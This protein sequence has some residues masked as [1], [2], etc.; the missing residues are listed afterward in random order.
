[1]TTTQRV[2]TLYIHTNASPLPLP[3]TMRQLV[4][5]RQ[6]IARVVAEVRV[7][8]RNP[9]GRHELVH[10]AAHVRVKVAAHLQTSADDR[11]REARETPS[12][13]RMSHPS[14]R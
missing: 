2:F 13:A 8:R 11:Q 14:D 3:L 10:G 6:D 9:L 1:M 12:A 4:R 5:V 7:V